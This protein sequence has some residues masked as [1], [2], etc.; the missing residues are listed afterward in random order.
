MSDTPPGTVYTALAPRGLEAL[1]AS[2]CAAGA[3]YLALVIPYWRERELAGQFMDPYMAPI[4]RGGLAWPAL[5]SLAAVVVV[6]LG[7]RPLPAQGGAAA[8]VSFVALALAL[9][10]GT[11][12]LAWWANAEAVYNVS[13][14]PWLTFQLFAL[15]FWVGPLAA[16]VA[17]AA[18]LGSRVQRRRATV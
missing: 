17:A 9:V 13:H 1:A 4:L 8:R 11:L 16:I 3:G 18:Y 14:H 12:V 7:R 6:R 10:C 2:F 5:L 15:P